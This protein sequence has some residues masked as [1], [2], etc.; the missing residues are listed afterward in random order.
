MP[1]PLNEWTATEIVQAVSSG[2]STAE[3]VVRACLE[4]VAAREAEVGAWT[5]IDPELVLIQAREFDRRGSG[6][7][8]AGVPFAVKD[9]I[10]TADY[11]TEFG[12]PIHRGRHAHRDAACVALS[13][14]AGGIVMGKS[15]TMPFPD[16]T[17]GKTR[18][19]VDTARTPGGSSSGSAAAVADCMVPLALGTQTT[20][21]TIRPASFCGVVG[22]R[23]TWGE[24]RLHGVL[25]VSGSVDTL[26]VLAR[27][28]EDVALY[29]DVLLGTP[30]EPLPDD[31]PAPRI[32]F[33]RTKL[34]DQVAAPVQKLAEGA[35]DDL[36]RAGATVIETELPAEFDRLAEA[37][38][39]IA[40]YEFARVFTWEIEHHAERINE[41]SRKRRIADG[42]ACDFSTYIGHIEYAERARLRMDDMWS[43]YDVIITPAATNEAPLGWDAIAGANWYMIWTVLH[44]PVV[45]VPVFTGPNGMPV[46]LQVFARRHRDR[47]LFSAARWIQRHLT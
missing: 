33:C 36:R 17:A 45:S 3:A 10:D 20:G 41:Y 18:N 21:S 7:A 14:K 13:K 26:G 2:R 15:V 12:S 43:D 38:R 37:H 47:E 25:E 1:K 32:A 30:H 24:H 28:V 40:G 42:L 5:T 34:W 6:G 39:W 4:R 35:A 8:I 46:G 29:R 19:P 31:A 27:S 9:I 23:P 22:Y 44:L 11:P 16:M